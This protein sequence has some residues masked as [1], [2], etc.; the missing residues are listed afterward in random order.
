MKA[1]LLIITPIIFTLQACAIKQPAPPTNIPINI[2]VQTEHDENEITFESSK[3]SFGYVCLSFSPQYAGEV[4]ARFSPKLYNPPIGYISIQEPS[5]ELRQGIKLSQS[6]SLDKLA[7]VSM[8]TAEIN[9]V[10]GSKKTTY[11]YDNSI[12][13]QFIDDC[14]RTTIKKW[15]ATIEK[16]DI[17]KEA[18]KQDILNQIDIVLKKHNK[19]SVS[20]GGEL[21]I[22]EVLLNQRYQ[23]KVSYRNFLNNKNKAYAVDFS[24]YRVSQIL[25]NNQYIL[26]NIIEDFYVPGLVPPLPIILKTKK[27]LFE[28]D[29]PT[30]GIAIYT[31]IELHQTISGVNKQFVSLTSLD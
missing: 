21:S 11:I 20:N 23:N 15:K 13:K 16:Q 22:N 17:L 8:F 27:Q 26:R 19:K 29:T 18:H 9:G 30:N 14:Q 1:K 10:K 28:G 25:G 7:L 31:G 12:I 3:G 24:G 5:T 4:K 2:T 6:E